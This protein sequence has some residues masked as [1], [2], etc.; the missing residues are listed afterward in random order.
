[1][2]LLIAITKILNPTIRSN[3]KTTF[4]KRINLSKRENEKRIE[5]MEESFRRSMEREQQQNLDNHTR[6]KR[7]AEA[8][9]GR[10]QVNV[11]Q[12]NE[13]FRRITTD[14]KENYDRNL[15]NLQR[16]QALIN[17]RRSDDTR[18]AVSNIR[19]IAEKKI[20][21]AVKRG[22]EKLGQQRSFLRTQHTTDVE[23]FRKVNQE[24]RDKNA[25]EIEQLKFSYDQKTKE[26]GRREELSKQ[27]IKERYEER[28]QI[29]TTE[30]QTGSELSK[31]P[32]KDSCQF[33]SGKGQASKK[34]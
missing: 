31:G 25:K 24:I 6:V 28:L 7:Q 23:N 26:S 19:R 32:K 18:K 34:I 17:R 4:D 27:D 15:D 29:T 20:N 2:N 9:I 30:Y 22:Q 16:R 10:L 12:K 5:D 1:M 21:I 14:L 13:D 33:I 11:I 8:E 3:I